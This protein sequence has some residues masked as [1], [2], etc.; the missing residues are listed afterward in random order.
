VRSIHRRIAEH[1]Q[2]LADYI[3]NPDAFDNQGLLRNAPTPEIR[4]RIIDGRIRHLQ[5]EIDAF[6]RQIDR[7]LGGG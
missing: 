4:Q 6:Q 1:Q 5:N 2:K 3:R 7:I